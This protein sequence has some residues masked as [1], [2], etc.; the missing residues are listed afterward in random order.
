MGA[1]FQADLVPGPPSPAA[2]GQDRLPLRADWESRSFARVDERDD[3]LLISA[4]ALQATHEDHA[5]V[6]DEFE[7]RQARETPSAITSLLSMTRAIVLNPADLN[8]LREACVARS[9][10]IRISAEEDFEIS[11]ART[12]SAVHLTQLGYLEALPGEG[13]RIKPGLKAKGKAALKV[14]QA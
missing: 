1:D 14:E 13:W 8:L 10:E 11:F 3:D 7:R 5:R 4:L 12:A 6:L 2:M 9:G